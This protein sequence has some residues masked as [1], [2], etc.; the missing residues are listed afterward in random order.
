[1]IFT[2]NGKKIKPAIKPQKGV[3]LST[4]KTTIAQKYLKY[5]NSGIF[6]ICKN[7]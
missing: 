4:Y 3:R 5:S 1:M 6:F 7:T 2:K